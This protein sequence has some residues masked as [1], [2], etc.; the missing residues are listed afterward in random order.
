MSFANDRSD[1]AFYAKLLTDELDIQYTSVNFDWNDVVGCLE[2][3]IYHTETYDPNSIRA[4]IPMFLLA[5]Y[6]RNNTDY[7]VFLSGEL[8]DELFAGYNYFAQVKTGHDL[9]TKTKRL[10]QNIHM[11][12][13]LRADRTFN[14]HGIEVRVPYA[15]RDFVRYI[16]S[17]EGQHKKFVKGIEKFLLRNAFRDVFPELTSTRIIMRAKERFSDGVSFDYVPKLLRYCDDNKSCILS[18]KEASEKS[19][20]RKIFSR[21]GGLDHLIIKRELP[22]W[23]NQ[24]DKDM[25]LVE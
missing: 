16:F 10:V 22:S 5:K 25:K 15:D 14:A 4:S 24:A 7:K 19:F 13:V 11:F 8:S 9:N 23:V 1:D 2:D 3:V 18:E 6:L 21:F 12:D 17:V 20:Y